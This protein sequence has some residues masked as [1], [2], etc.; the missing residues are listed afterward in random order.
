MSVVK[1][2]CCLLV[3]YQLN[4][5]KKIKGSRAGESNVVSLRRLKIH[6]Q[7]YWCLKHKHGSESFR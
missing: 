1:V 4:E 5:A 2:L 3:V 7:L 6:L